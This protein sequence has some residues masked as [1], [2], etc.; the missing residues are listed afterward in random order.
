LGFGRLIISSESKITVK[1]AGKKMP[2][3]LSRNEKP[4]DE[5]IGEKEPTSLHNL[6][7]KK[8]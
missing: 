2:G 6:L 5:F 4:F 3:N 7:L 1:V 8:N